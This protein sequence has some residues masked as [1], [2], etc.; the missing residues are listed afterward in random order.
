MTSGTSRTYSGCVT[1]SFSVGGAMAGIGGAGIGAIAIGGGAIIGGAIIIIGGGAGC[2]DQPGFCSSGRP[3]YSPDTQ[4]APPRPSAAPSSVSSP[5]FRT[6]GRSP[7]T[8]GFRMY[9]P[10]V[11]LSAQ[12]LQSV[13]EMMPRRRNLRSLVSGEG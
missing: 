3:A 12:P 9:V 2:A 1:L 11:V 4:P 7:S 8:D 6:I 5:V 10:T 13:E